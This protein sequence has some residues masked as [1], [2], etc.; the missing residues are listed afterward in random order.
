MIA[1]VYRIVNTVTGDFY[2]GS[3]VNIDRRKSIHFFDLRHDKHHSPILQ[4]SFNKYGEDKMAFE[5]IETVSAEDIHDILERE[6]FY[7][8]TLCPKFNVCQIAGSPL[9]IKHTEQARANMSSAHIGKK[10]SRET[11]DKRTA[12]QSGT[13]HYG[14][15]KSRSNDTKNKIS[16]KLKEYYTEHAVHN[17]GG[18]ISEEQ[19]GKIAKKLMKPVIQ[20]T[21]DMVYVMEWESGKIAG[22]SLKIQP[23]AIASC[24]NGKLKSAG[25]FIWR[26][27]I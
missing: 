18:V 12:K 19:R 11:I 5:I 2:I 1:Y 8:D 20:Y 15:G 26:H 27:K 6:Q 24:C 21:K 9:G 16:K 10:L 25:G 14:Y 22:Q 13:N 4:N 23:G 7:I 3:S 17:K